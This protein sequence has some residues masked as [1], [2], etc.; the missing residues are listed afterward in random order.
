MGGWNG[1]AKRPWRQGWGD[2]A[3]SQG[4][5]AATR[6]QEG[7]GTDSPQ[8]PEG[9]SRPGGW[10]VFVPSGFPQTNLSMGS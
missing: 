8:E 3:V 1:K 4:P 6:Q 7:Q 2:T 9:G 5:S 10:E